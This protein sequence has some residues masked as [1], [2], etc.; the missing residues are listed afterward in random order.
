MCHLLSLQESYLC[1]CSISWLG[2]MSNDRNMK[3]KDP[4]W[5]VKGLYLLSRHTTGTQ[6]DYCE[7][8]NYS[9]LKGNIFFNLSA[10][11]LSIPWSTVRPQEWDNQGKYGISPLNATCF[12]FIFLNMPTGFLPCCNSAPKP[13]TN[14]ER[15]RKSYS[16]PVFRRLL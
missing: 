6:A 8:S 7:A 13:K 2:M 4:V 11:I 9:P 15:E 12:L 14:K 3:K 10:P 16:L 1:C 5:S